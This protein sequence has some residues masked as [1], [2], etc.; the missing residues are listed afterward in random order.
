MDNKEKKKPDEQLETSALNT[1][2]LRGVGLEKVKDVADRLK[3]EGVL[4]EKVH[5][6]IVELIG[7]AEKEIH[8]YRLKEAQGPILNLLK[9]SASV[10]AD[11]NELVWEVCEVLAKLYEK[12]EL[13]EKARDILEQSLSLKKATLGEKDASY[14]M[15]LIEYANCLSTLGQNEK[16]DEIFKEAREL[17]KGNQDN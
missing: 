6:E 4:P 16:A 3:A 2:S 5:S 14:I 7:N 11:T 13:H 9:N 8:E 1:L 10:D 17:K 15:S 12:L